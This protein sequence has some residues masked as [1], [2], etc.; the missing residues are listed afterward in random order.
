VP[1]FPA[2][3]LIDINNDGKDDM[4]V[5]PNNENIS[6]NFKNIWY[7]EN[8]SVDE[9]Y[10]FEFQSDSFLVGD[11]VDVGD[12]AFPVFFDYNYDGLQDLIIGNKGYFDAG[13]Y[14][15]MLALYENTGSNTDPEF[16][17][18]T[19]DFAGI[20][21]F[22]I[23]SICPTFG[24][25]D[26]DGD[27]DMLIG[28]EEGF[29]H[30]FQNIAPESGPAEFVLFAGNYQGIDPGQNSTPQ[31]TDISGDGLPDLIV[32]EK[33]G[34]L[35]YYLNTGTAG[36]PEFTLEDEF[37]GAVD[38]RE[39]GVLTGH[40][41]PM[42]ITSGSTNELYVGSEQGT[43]FLYEPTED[44]TGPFTEI[45]SEFNSI[46]EGSFSSARL[47]DIT[48]D[49]FLEMITGNERGGIAL[50]RDASTVSVEEIYQQ[51]GSVLLSPN[52]VLSQLHVQYTGREP[53]E[54]ICVYS[55]NGA[56]VLQESLLQSNH[57]EIDMEDL[58]SGM[59]IL[60]LTT[61]E[62]NTSIR[63]KFIKQ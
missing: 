36:D 29:L 4:V 21:V 6:E 24:D 40:S 47:M 37:W 48:G 16:T 63:T 35:N 54:K 43:I 45:T 9:T 10:V 31:L 50:Y 26:N 59:Y 12:R 18:V 27:A 34:N 7:Y 8:T 42:L 39:A 60:Q 57:F 17:L 52:P 55:I 14:N 3:F 51:P 33:N 11:M 44:F 5:S 20:S 23:N 15:A 32:G 49:G 38:V 61:A 53:V 62:D 56:I 46:D 13:D 58:P 2:A 22:D 19:R 1:I 41:V 25:I 28:D 30:Y